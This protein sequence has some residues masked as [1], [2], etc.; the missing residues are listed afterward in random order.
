MKITLRR[1][2]AVRFDA[3][4]ERGH[5]FV[6]DGPEKMGGVD[7]GM[8]PMELFLVSLA[9]CAAMDVVHIL[10]RQREP[11]EDLSIHVEG[12][13]AD[14]VPAVYERIH[15]RFDA[16]G[17]VLRKK[18]DRAVALSV[19]KYCSVRSMLRDEVVVTHSTTLNGV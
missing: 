16:T 5:S 1:A 15:L 2:S 18:L 14:A 3:A 10:T 4:D 12:T 6:L 19:D 13:R 9:G 17:E 8:R 7:A 11:L